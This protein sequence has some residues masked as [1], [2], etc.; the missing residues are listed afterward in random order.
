MGGRPSQLVVGNIEHPF[1]DNKPHQERIQLPN[2]IIFLDMDK[3]KKGTFLTNEPAPDL[4]RL[5]C[6]FGFCAFEPYWQLTITPH[7]KCT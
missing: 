6:H 5:V 2:T 1:V 7:L 4:K 3:Q